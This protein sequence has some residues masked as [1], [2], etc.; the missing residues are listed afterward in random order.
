VRV[1]L[2]L[3]VIELCVQLLLFQRCFLFTVEVPVLQQLNAGAEHDDGAHDVERV[4]APA[5]GVPECGVLYRI[6]HFPLQAVKRHADGKYQ[7]QAC[8]IGEIAPLEQVLRHKPVQVQVY[9]QHLYPYLP[10]S[11]LKGWI[12][13]A[14]AIPQEE[15][16]YIDSPPENDVGRHPVVQEEVNHTLHHSKVIISPLKKYPCITL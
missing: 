2:S 11:E 15:G 4:H 1:D 3:E 9:D 7:Q 13:P 10:G 12:W 16:A 8:R 5:D 14:V 6:H